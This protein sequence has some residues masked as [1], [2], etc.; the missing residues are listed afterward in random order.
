MLFQKSKL[1]RCFIVFILIIFSIPFSVNASNNEQS[2]NFDYNLYYYN[3]LNSFEKTIYDNL[4]K[5]QESFLNKEQVIFLITTYD[6]KNNANLQEYVP[7]VMK[8]RIAY[9]YDNPKVDIWFDSYKCTLYAKEGNIYL[10]CTLK[11]ENNKDI[12]FSSTNLK[13]PIAEFEKKCFEIA[14]SLSGSDEEKLKQLHDYL[15]ENAIYDKTISAPNTRTAYGNIMEGHSVCSGFAF[16]YKYIADLAGLKV[17]YVVGNLYD[18]QK[19]EYLLHAWNVAYV[20]GKY[21]LIDTT[22]DI[23][24]NSKDHSMFFLSPIQDGMHYAESNYFSYTF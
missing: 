17:L 4:I 22:L 15:T 8:A 6:A 23:P 9:I 14:N 1:F 11:D 18:K 10:K 3:Q 7:S 16:A 2:L 13:E 12:A 5:S 19:N 24:T 21:L 20:N